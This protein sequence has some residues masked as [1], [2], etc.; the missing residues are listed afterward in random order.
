[1]RDFYKSKRFLVLVAVALAVVIIPV[2]LSA[3]GLGSTLRGAVNTILS[4]GQK[5][6]EKITTA[7][8]GYSA[9]FTEFD[10]ISAENGEMKAEL[11]ALKEKIAKDDKLERDYEWLSRFIE[12]KREH[13]DYSL[14]DCS[15]TGHESG[16]YWTTLTID[17]GTA[18]GVGMGMPVITE[19]GIVGSVVEV[20]ATWAKVETLLNATVRLGGM[21][22]RSGETGLVT[23][24]FVMTKDG[25]CKLTYLPAESDVRE[26]DRVMTS[27]Y[28]SVYPRG[29]L[30]GTVTRVEADSYSQSITAY[31]EPAV[32]LRDLT[33]MMIITDYEV[34]MENGDE[35][36]AE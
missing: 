4:P 8:G 33:R 15:V 5:L 35:Q 9:Y 11:N 27:G 31:I 2:T 36:N 12:L 26:G 13:T 24:D 28:G 19:D 29:L 10:R 3:M 30:V 32:G 23:S 7:L 20:G 1:M 17:R 21:I 18:H 6:F 34:M 16:N 25:E 14:L 22:E